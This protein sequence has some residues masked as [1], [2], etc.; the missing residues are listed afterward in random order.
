MCQLKSKLIFARLLVD[1]VGQELLHP[2]LR[3]FH[4]L[5]PP[6]KSNPCI[7]RLRRPQQKTCGSGNASLA[8]PLSPSCCSQPP[9]SLA[10]TSDE[11]CSAPRKSTLD[12]EAQLVFSLLGKSMH[13]LILS[14]QFCCWCRGRTV[15]F[16]EHCMWCALILEVVCCNVKHH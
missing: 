12:G 11:C 1:I 15:G 8:R 10:D 5:L 4:I 2:S 16:I 9:S 14:V 6:I 3:Y 7:W 13:N